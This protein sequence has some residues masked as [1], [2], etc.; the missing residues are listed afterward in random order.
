[1]SSSRTVII[2]V[3]LLLIPG[4]TARAQETHTLAAAAAPKE[5]HYEG[6]GHDHEHTKGKEAHESMNQWERGSVVRSV[7]GDTL[8]LGAAWL[9]VGGYLLLAQRRRK[10]KRATVP[11]VPVQEAGR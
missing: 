3:A 2:A 8:A 9:G 7:R 6:D 10:T 11:L 4:M 1:M 5:T